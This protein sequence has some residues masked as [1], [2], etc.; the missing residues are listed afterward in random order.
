MYLRLIAAGRLARDAELRSLSSGQVIRF[1]IPHSLTLSSGEEKTQWIECSYW[2]N[3]GDSIEVLKH[4]RKGAV[5]LVEGVPSARFYTRQDNTPGVSLECRVTN[6][7][8]LVYAPSE[9]LQP[10][11][12]SMQADPVEPVPPELP[13]ESDLPF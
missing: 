7:R 10:P 9:A 2:R 4:L 11:G 8:I 13:D 6:L 5:V 3:P 1:S 12:A